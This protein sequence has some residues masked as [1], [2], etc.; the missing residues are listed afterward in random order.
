MYIFCLSCFGITWIIHSIKQDLIFFVFLHWEVGMTCKSEYKARFFISLL[1]LTVLKQKF[2]MCL[3]STLPSLKHS[4][5]CHSFICFIFSYQSRKLYHFHYIVSSPLILKLNNSCLNES[6]G[7]KCRSSLI[8]GQIRPQRSYYPCVG[9]YFCII[10]C[11]QVKI[12][13]CQ[14]SYL[15]LK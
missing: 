3:C 2:T 14:Q 7:V 6:M 8:L 13:I 1:L 4:P 10:P 5:I 11:F 9:K 12:Y 15:Y